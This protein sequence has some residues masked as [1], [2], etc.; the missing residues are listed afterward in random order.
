MSVE[1]LFTLVDSDAPVPSY[2]HPGDAGL[3]LTTRQACALEPGE[4][5]LLPTGIAIAMPS[6]P[7]QVPVSNTQLP[8]H[9]TY[10]RIAYH[11]D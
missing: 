8:A 4:R 11:V 6:G 3:D 10:R 7:T 5:A 1:V 2:A 9:Q